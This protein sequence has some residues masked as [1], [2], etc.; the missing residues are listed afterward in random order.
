MKTISP[1]IAELRLIISRTPAVHGEPL[2][3]DFSVIYLRADPMAQLSLSLRDAQGLLLHETLLSRLGVAPPP[4]I[5]GATRHGRLTLP[6]PLAPGDYRLGL[7]LLCHSP[8]EESVRVEAPFTVPAPRPDDRFGGLLHLAAAVTEIQ[9]SEAMLRDCAL[10][11]SHWAGEVP[12]QLDLNRAQVAGLVSGFFPRETHVEGGFRWTGPHAVFQLRTAGPAVTAHVIAARPDIH[13]HPV[14]VELFAG[15]HE[16]SRLPLTSGHAHLR[17]SLPAELR[18]KV[19]VFTLKT[20]DPWRPADLLAGNQDR[21]L[22]GLA[23]SRLE[24]PA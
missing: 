9:P 19:T 16:I 15:E 4:P 22:L 14:E 18:G 11:R 3:A 2:V 21:R 8:D 23:L 20:S 12:A 10:R 5:F 24:S 6:M 17:F 1:P 7:A 13:R